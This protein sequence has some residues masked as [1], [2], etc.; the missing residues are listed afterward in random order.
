MHHV[1]HK[2]RALDLCTPIGLLAN[3]MCQTEYR[4]KYG[5]NVPYTFM[6]N[7]FAN[8]GG[9]KFCSV[10][11]QETLLARA[12][13]YN[14]GCVC[15]V[16]AVS[17][18]IF[19]KIVPIIWLLFQVKE[20]P[21]KQRFGHREWRHS[22]NCWNQTS[23]NKFTTENGFRTSFTICCEYLTSHGLQMKPSSICLDRLIHKIP[24]YEPLRTLTWFTKY[25]C[26]QRK[27]EFAVPYWS[28]HYW[29]H[30]LW[31]TLHTITYFH[32]FLSLENSWT[33]SNSLKVTSSKMAQ[34]NKMYV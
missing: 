12:Q 13:G 31:G 15:E 8:I 33:M 28:K 10:W 34:L 14:S 9:N 23:S 1:V 25:Y 6:I 18:K 2:E 19:V 7:N 16:R 11:M 32:I 4:E 21:T 3:A 22:T 17:Q 24:V 5:C 27:W 20:V 26:I 30:F 29:S